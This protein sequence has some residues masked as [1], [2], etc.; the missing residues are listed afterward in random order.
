[1]TLFSP[2][3]SLS[4]FRD[5]RGSTEALWFDKYRKVRQQMEYLIG[6]TFR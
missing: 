1:L 3:R 4:P 2:P 5:S 6:L